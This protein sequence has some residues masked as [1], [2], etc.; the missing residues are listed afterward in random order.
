MTSLAGR[1]VAI[2]NRAEIAVRVAAT[3][4]R[5]G[6]IPI[7]LLEEPERTGYAAR[8]IGRA[9]IIGPIGSLFEV[10]RVIAGAE[11]VRADFLHPGYGF[12]SERADLAAACR[13]AGITFVGPSAETLRLCG[14]KLATREAAVAAGVPILPASGPLGD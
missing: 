6:M 1:R 2:A 8:Q 10:E 5:L 3:C 9:E 13:G 11:R 7:V 12:L 4:R 14:D